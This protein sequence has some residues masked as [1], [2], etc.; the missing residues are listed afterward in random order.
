MNTTIATESDIGREEAIS[1]AKLEQLLS[2]KLMAGYVLMEITCPKCPT[3]LIKNHQIV[4]KMLS[5]SSYDE[6]DTKKVVDKAVLLPAE[7]FEQPFKPVNG[8]PFCVHCNSHV[9]TQETE[10]AILEECDTL[11]DKGSIYVALETTTESTTSITEED[12][13]DNINSNN[14]NSNNRHDIIHLEDVTEDDIVVG[15]HRRKFLVDIESA[16]FDNNG[17]SHVEMVISPRMGDLAK[18]INVEEMDEAKDDKEELHLRR[19]IATKVLGAKMLQGWTLKETTCGPCGMPVMEHKGVQECVVCPALAKRAKKKLKQRQKIDVQFQ[20]ELAHQQKTEQQRFE[21]IQ[22]VRGDIEVRAIQEDEEATQRAEKRR[23]AIRDEKARI[24]LLAQQQK[25]GQQKA[26]EKV[27]EEEVLPAEIQERDR[28]SIEEE[29]I[30]LKRLGVIMK[31]EEER[32]N[33]KAKVRGK[34][35]QLV[36][37]EAEG[38]AQQE[39]EAKELAKEAKAIEAFDEETMAD[40][41]TEA[42]KK[43]QL[44]EEHRK[45]MAGKV[46]LDEQVAK[47]EEDRLAE[48][49][50]VRKIAEERRNE[51]ESR[52]IAALEADAAIKALAAEDAIRRAK[53]ALRDVSL[54]K[55]QIISQTIELAEKEIVAETEESLRARFEDHNEPVILQSE[56]EIYI[57]RWETLRLEGRSIMTRRMLQGWSITPEACRAAECHESPLIEKNGRKECVVCG[58]SG[59]GTDGVFVT[60]EEEENV[61]ATP[62]SLPP[63]VA[64]SMACDDYAEEEW[65]GNGHEVE[66]EKKR[67]FYSKEIGKRMLMGWMLVDSSCPNCIMPLMMDNEGNTDIC[68]VKGC[69][70]DA[71]TIATNSTIA[72]IVTKDMAALEIVEEGPA[73]ALS[74]VVECT[75]SDESDL[76]SAI[77]RQ[78]ILKQQMKTRPCKPADPPA[79]KPVTRGRV[80][81]ETIAKEV[82]PLPPK[83]DFADAAALRELVGVEEEQGRDDTAKDASIDTVA[84]LFLRSPHGYDFQDFGKSM[85]ID[86]VKELVDIFLVTNVDNDVSEDFKFAVAQRIL[87]KM[88]L[89]EASNGGREETLPPRIEAAE[90]PSR[91]SRFH[92]DDDEQTATKLTGQKATT[93]QRSKPCPEGQNSAQVR[94]MRPPK[95]PRR[96]KQMSPVYVVGGPQSPRDDMSVASRASSIASDALE[97][98]Y[99]RIE[100]CKMKLLDPAN[101]LDE[102]IATAALLEKL[103][104]A[105][106]A[107]KEMECL[108]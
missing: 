38:K 78:A 81:T 4:P 49:M 44:V 74:P 68:I 39:A 21:Q 72:T 77:K 89:A 79:F 60:L 67:E 101:N 40:D 45:R 94:R 52:M 76:V 14:N 57:E 82:I 84:N 17:A 107:V 30:E 29:R 25:E 3:P 6:H 96:Y 75:P 33:M 36:S 55:H 9:I 26:N 71:S 24:H 106:V 100:Q 73:R 7:S 11:K 23:R 15:S 56:S 93:K 105:A 10:I 86:E 1:D 108:E 18:P 43:D 98:I 62:T 85:G 2:E 28:V 97:S 70:F 80:T 95:S 69:G 12:K 83:V 103:A 102:Q 66:F 51:T 65:L 50:E 27:K 99:D 32:R 92:F 59:S 48:A 53:K 13:M 91:P 42:M 87:S 22:T 34:E 61:S 88:N 104:Q 90:R 47:L 20:K 54:T 8:V 5:S 63:L 31:E 58:G 16:S 41:K 64:K 46:T 37:E 35:E 19:D